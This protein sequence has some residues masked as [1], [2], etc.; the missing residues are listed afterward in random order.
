MTFFARAAD[1]IVLN[2]VTFPV[3]SMNGAVCP[4]ILK[5]L[6]LFLPGHNAG[7]KIVKISK[8]SQFV[9]IYVRGINDKIIALK[10]IEVK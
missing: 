4:M 8:K 10:I 3:L 6:L 9:I 2:I 1:L 7:S 5:N